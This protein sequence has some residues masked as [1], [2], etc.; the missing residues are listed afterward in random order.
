MPLVYRVEDKDGY[1]MYMGRSTPVVMTMQD[2]MRHPTPSKDEKLARFWNYLTNEECIRYNFGF[3][4]MEQLK[5]WIY[6]KKW[7]EDL[8][9]EGF[10]VSVYDVEIV[11]GGDT[12]AIFFRGSSRP[13]QVISLLEI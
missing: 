1:G 9:Q 8:T 13:Q 10:H 12:Q 6:E 5:F 3:V 4:S 11:V 7:R 2:S